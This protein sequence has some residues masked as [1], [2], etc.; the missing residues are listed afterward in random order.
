[1]EQVK[2]KSSSSTKKWLIGCGI[3]CGAVLLIVIILVMGGFFYVRNIV[4]GFKSSEVLM[5]TLVEQHGQIQEYSPSPD[6]EIKAQ[7]LEAFLAVRDAIIPARE[8][9]ETS[10]RILQDRDEEGLSEEERGGVI[11]KI[12]TGFGMIGQIADFH[13]ARIQALLDTGMGM[14]E[15]YYI[16]TIV[17]YSW[18]EKS[19]LDGH[20]FQI[21][22]DDEGYRF[23]EWQDEESEEIRRD[24]TLRWL[25]RILLPMLH[26]QHQKLIESDLRGISKQWPEELETEIE[27][28]ESN[29]YRLVWQDGLPEITKRSLEPFRG[30]LDASYSPLT[31]GV[32]MALER[33]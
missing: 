26:N 3:G 13:K 10:L 15:Y 5:D 29:R 17:Y 11:K 19:V 31:N 18:L 9:L 4:E 2:P 14:G 21:R 1:M 8:E 27:A 22:G 12:T 16:Y 24:M 32:E 30:R 33:R 23:N 28:M 25:H 7:R 6:G 20:D